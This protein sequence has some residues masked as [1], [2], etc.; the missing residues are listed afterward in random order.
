MIAQLDRIG[1][2]PNVCF[3]QPC[4]KGTRIWASLLLDLL[5]EGLSEQQILVEYP[6][7]KREDILAALAYGA[8]M[9]REHIIPISIENA[10]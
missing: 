6:Q 7:L 2:D 10:A 5:A 1:I 3:G 4:I 8:E 9:A